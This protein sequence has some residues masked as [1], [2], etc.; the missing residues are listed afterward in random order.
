MYKWFSYSLYI[1]STIFFNNFLSNETK[2]TDL[3]VYRIF[4]YIESMIVVF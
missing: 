4:F 1:L 2:Y 3:R